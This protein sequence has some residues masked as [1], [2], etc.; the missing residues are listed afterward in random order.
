VGSRNIYSGLQLLS[1]VQQAKAKCVL[2]TCTLYRIVTFTSCAALAKSMP[3]TPLKKKFKPDK[4]AREKILTFEDGI[5][6]LVCAVS[7]SGRF[8]P[9]STDHQPVRIV[10]KN[11]GI[12]SVD[13]YEEFKTHTSG[14]KTM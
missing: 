14:L 1:F 5:S 6:P 11:F 13:A 7:E 8:A 9:K 2:G 12:L 4:T 10:V 3:K